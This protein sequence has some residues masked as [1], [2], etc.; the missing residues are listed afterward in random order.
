MFLEIGRTHIKDVVESDSQDHVILNILLKLMMMGYDPDPSKVQERIKARYQTSFWKDFTD[1][2]HSFGSDAFRLEM[3]KKFE[4]VFMTLI[5]Q[6]V[7]LFE[8]NPDD[9]FEQFNYVDSNDEMFDDFFKNKRD[10]GSILREII[11]LIGVE[12][13]SV[14]LN[15]KLQAAV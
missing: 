7:M 10:L 1:Y 9:T 2:F 12:Q 5:N 8:V 14:I 4:F 13:V 3:L 15:E 6:I 11:K